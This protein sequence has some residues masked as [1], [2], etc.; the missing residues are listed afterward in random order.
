MTTVAA[1]VLDLAGDPIAL[2]AALVDTPSPSG[3]EGPLADAVWAALS[4]QAP[5]LALLR[6]GDALVARTSFGMADRVVIAG[7]LDTVPIADNLPSVLSGTSLL[8]GCGSTDMKG[9]VAV[10]LHLA[11]T[12]TSAL[13]DVTYLFY[14]HEEVEAAKN[15]LGRI[16]RNHPEWLDG[17]LAILME[18]TGSRIE[19]G[20]QGTMR[21]VVTLAGRRAHTARNWIGINAIHAAAPVLSRL[22]SYDARRVVIDGCEYREGLS[23]VGISGGVAGNVVPDSCSVTVNLRF[24]PD[25]SVAD[26][27]AHLRG[28]FDG[29]DLASFTVVDF[30]AGA[31]PGLSAPAAASFVA[32]VG[33]S[34]LAKLGWTDVAR[35]AARGIPAVNFGPGDALIA[36]TKDEW[37][38]TREITAAAAILTRYLTG[39]A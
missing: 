36:H 2:T 7:H 21:A 11:A 29:L 32:A 35:F 13:Y 22:A 19:A 33:G 16:E 37:V 6:D 18:P 10:A 24:A 12:V 20:C 17:D 23:A 34:P 27:E 14:D 1:P 38:D 28:V 31:L 15:G 26:A 30:S 8:Y 3:S 5:H 39:G 9:G 25:R 4:L